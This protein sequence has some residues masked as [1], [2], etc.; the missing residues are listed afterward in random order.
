MVNQIPSAVCY[1]RLPWIRG[2]FDLQDIY[3]GVGSDL[4]SGNSGQL[5][6]GVGAH[7]IY[8]YVMYKLRF[9]LS[10][11]LYK[12]SVQVATCTNSL[13]KLQL[14]W[15][16]L[17]KLQH[18][19]VLDLYKLQLAQASYLLI[20]QCIIMKLNFNAY[21]IYIFKSLSHTGPTEAVS[22]F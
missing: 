13:Y 3:I 7:V 2:W 16:D 5:V 6:G 18:V 12:K 19:Q 10:C 4:G 1:V 14:V 22:D 15:V 17:Y 21:L 11:H 8:V 9:C 20:E